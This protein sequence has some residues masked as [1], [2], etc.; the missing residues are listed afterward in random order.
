M[1]TYFISG[2]RDATKEEFEEH[3][4]P[5]LKKLFEVP[6]KFILG[7]C[8]GIDSFAIDYLK[9]NNVENVIVYHIGETPMYNREFET[10]GGFVG[11]MYRDFTMTL[12]SDIDICWIRK[13]RSGTYLNVERRTWVNSRKASG[14]SYSFEDRVNIEANLFL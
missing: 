9:E 6:N 1:K 5:I 3:Y 14:L 4:V 2:H 12:N 7:D 11:D 10:R 8:P 13:M